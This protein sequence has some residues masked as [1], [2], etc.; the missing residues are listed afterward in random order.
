MRYSSHHVAGHRLNRML[1][2]YN[3]NHT[4]N[5]SLAHEYFPAQIE[6]FDHFLP[7]TQPDKYGSIC[8]MNSSFIHFLYRKNVAGN[9]E[10]EQIYAFVFYD[11]FQQE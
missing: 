2:D 8:Q 9:D 5:Q 4:T 1:P 10:Y 11:K 6:Q 3:M 7:Q